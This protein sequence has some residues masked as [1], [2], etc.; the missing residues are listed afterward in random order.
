MDRRAKVEL[1]EQIRR[2][3]EFGTGSVRGVAK[4]LGVHRRLVRQALQSAVPPERKTVRRPC[5]R[6]DPIKPFIE[7]VLLGD[8]QAP[9]KQRHTAHR[10]WVR[11]CQEFP[12]F[13]VAES[14]LRAHVRERKR[15]LGLG[16]GE[17]YVPQCYGWG[18]EGQVD[19][20]EACAVLDD[21]TAKVQ[22]FAL[23]SMKSGAAFHRAYR[24]ATQ[25]A[26]FEAH[27]AAFVYFGGVFRTLRYDNLGSAV[28]KVLRGHTRDEHTRFIA[29]RS[30]WGFAAEFC[31]PAQ[32]QEKGG[33][34]GE[35]G[36]FRRNH[37]VPVPEAA[38]LAA[39][40][41]FLLAACQADESRILGDRSATV[42]ERALRERDDLLPLAREGFDLAE[43]R[44]CVV[45]GKGC[46]LTHTNW[47]STPLSSGTRA[48]VRVLP[49]VV[50]VWHA[51]KSVACHER[52]YGRSQQV[53]N[54]EHYLDVLQRKPGALAGSVP[55]S[56]WRA[57]G[58]WPQSFDRLWEGLIERQGKPAGTAAMVHLL[59]LARE[60]GWDALRRAVDTA[61]SEGCL[62][63]SAV[64][65]LLLLPASGGAPAMLTREDL[66]G[67]CRFDRP[68]PEMS[69]YDRLLG[70]AR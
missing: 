11:V 68:Q 31:N 67:L 39:L 15:A 49:S 53:L 9:R 51:G 36:T 47:Y 62:D 18:E 25:Q 42:G 64:R 50:E 2:E 38:D 17:T 46:V 44:S 27:E 43:S 16:V 34:E 29:F 70:G 40:N 28:K 14:T 5:P 13:S 4:K 32:P 1:F 19:W 61:L 58:R 60:H 12:A 55:L 69:E 35:V 57:Q 22:V 66:G 54:L 20:Y 24:H 26:F 63:E 41:A 37:L 65:C 7:A 21:E 10:I 52:S 23:R 30:H 59:L 45:D 48:Q 8:K 33:V 56:Q 6:L 3:Y